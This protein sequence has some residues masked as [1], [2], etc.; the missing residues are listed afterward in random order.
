MVVDIKKYEEEARIRHIDDIVKNPL[1]VMRIKF[2]EIFLN[3]DAPKLIT[4]ESVKEIH[5][6][7]EKMF[8]KM[9]HQVFTATQIILMLALPVMMN[10][11]YLS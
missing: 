2:S 8:K 4:V 10:V 11:S 3:A 7:L 5:A 6:K 1:N 9:E